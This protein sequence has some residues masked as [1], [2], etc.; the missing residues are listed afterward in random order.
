MIDDRS[1]EKVVRLQIIQ[2]C[3][4]VV[5]TKRAQLEKHAIVVEMETGE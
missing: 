2:L 4:H 3:T 5:H 1:K